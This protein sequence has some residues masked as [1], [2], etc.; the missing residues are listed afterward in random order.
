MDKRLFDILIV[1]DEEQNRYLLRLLCA[2]QGYTVHEAADGRQA[3]DRAQALLPDLI[4]FDVNMSVL[5]GFAVLHELKSDPATAHIPVII[6]TALDSHEDRLQGIAAGASDFLNKP[7]EEQELTLLLRNNL[8]LKEYEDFLRHHA[9]LLEKRVAQ[10]T[11]ELRTAHEAVQQAYRETISRLTLASECRDRET[12][13]H[14]RRTSAYCRV[15][16]LALGESPAFAEMLA[17]VAPMHDLGKVG[18]PDH[19]LL[20]PG[21]LD[22]GEWAV[23]RRHA[24]DGHG[25]LQGA[26]VPY[27]AMA[28]EVA[29]AHHERWDGSGYPRGLRGEEIPLAA[30]IMMLADIYD[31]LRSARPYKEAMTHEDAMRKITEGDGRILPRHF[32]PRLLA[33][34][35]D[36]H[37][38][39][40]AIFDGTAK[41]AAK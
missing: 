29:F 13:A 8:H 3:V 10:R 2:N 7:V 26:Q 17:C 38:Q 12:G 25:I 36:C 22:D 19:I 16:A 39:L 32:D 27:L 21:P 41:D 1:D 6:L 37:E 14:I 28:D 30:R 20:K 9:R 34:L 23:M 11:A 33:A 5:D 15:L 35:A 18:V 31:A 24:R 4:I 40:R